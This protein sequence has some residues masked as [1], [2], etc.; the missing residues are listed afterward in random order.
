MENHHRSAV[1]G[2]S[3][4]PYETAL[5][6]QCGQAMNYSSVGSPS[7]PNYL[8]AT[9]GGT[10]GVVDDAGPGMHRINAD[11]LFRDVRMSGRKALSYE[12]DMPQNCALTSSGKYA[13]K[14]NPAAYFV[15]PTDRQACRTDNVPMGTTTTGAFINALTTD[16]LPAFA[17]IT[18]NLCHD[19]HDCDV[20]QGDAWLS[21][22]VPL[23]LASAA[24]QSGTTAL[25]IAWD[26]PTEMPFL[27]ITPTTAPGTK[28]TPK[29]NHYAL[30]RTTEEMLGLTKWLGH[31]ATAPSM[32]TMFNL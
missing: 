32:R 9:S 12:E 1:I 21:T 10:H 14:H 13:V 19:T 16:S 17:F 22:W 15:G 26:E 20:P 28:A 8:G 4:A 30:L 6:A 27:A 3:G 31:A 29:V 23:I 18:P 2:N 25:F 24:Y 11:N 5:A 7:L